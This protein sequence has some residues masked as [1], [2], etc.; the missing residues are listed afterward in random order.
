[1]GIFVNALIIGWVNLAL[2]SLLQVFFGLSSAEAL[3]WTFVAMMIVFVYS[4]FS[5]LLGV[6]YTDI[7]QFTVAMTG[8][9]V[10]AVLVI[11]SDQIG[12]IDGLK[13]AIPEQAIA[14]FPNISRLVPPSPMAIHFAF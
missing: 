2:M 7:V 5:G 11:N 3:A 9:I 10:L 6:V 13:A 14:F 8:S 12:G 4:G 1:M